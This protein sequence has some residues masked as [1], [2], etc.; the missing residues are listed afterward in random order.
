MDCIYIDIENISLNI[1][2]IKEL[3]K[4][5]KTKIKCI[6]HLNNFKPDLFKELALLNTCFINVKSKEKDAADLTIIKEIGKDN[7]N[8]ICI[9]SNDNIF[10]TTKKILEEEGI[11]CKIIEHPEEIK[12]PVTKTKTP[13]TKQKTTTANKE[14][15]TNIKHNFHQDKIKNHYLN[16]LNNL[17][18]NTDNFFI[19]LDKFY[20]KVSGDKQIF[21]K[22]TNYKS[23]LKVTAS[24]LEE[25]KI[26]ILDNP[27]G[28]KVITRRGKVKN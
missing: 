2:N 15:N 21:I 5:P 8:N 10:K 9:I 6:G 19:R 12:K 23:W 7:F 11:T 24:L 4:S 17:L 14:K 13:T 3:K 16:V 1:I 28:S 26:K 25:N 20:G 18:S 22:N 27:D